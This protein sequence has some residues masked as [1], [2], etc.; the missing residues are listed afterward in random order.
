MNVSFYGPHGNVAAHPAKRKR[1]QPQPIAKP[2]PKTRTRKAFLFVGGN[3]H[4][5][6]CSGVW[7]VPESAVPGRI[8]HYIRTARKREVECKN[9]ADLDVRLA[10]VFGMIRMWII[11]E[12]PASACVMTESTMRIA[13]QL[14]EQQKPEV[15]KDA[16]DAKVAKVAKAE[17]PRGTSDCPSSPN[18]DH[19][20]D[21][22]RKVWM[23]GG[24]GKDASA[25]VTQYDTLELVRFVY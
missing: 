15:A 9:N 20:D 25:S 6:Y 12:L 2:K 19:G 4:H 11:S 1:A 8:R 23:H 3:V 14:L 21:D 24:F 10:E 17:E 16:E 7:L 13:P 18:F 5:T 22:K